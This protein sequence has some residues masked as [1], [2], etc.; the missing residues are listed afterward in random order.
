MKPG[1]V[2]DRSRKSS[3]LDMARMSIFFH[4]QLSLLTV[5]IK[6]LYHLLV[7]KKNDRINPSTLQVNIR[8]FAFKKNF[9]HCVGGFSLFSYNLLTVTVFSSYPLVIVIIKCSQTTEV[10]RPPLR[11]QVALV[12]P[13]KQT[14]KQTQQ[15]FS[16][17]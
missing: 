6:F 11:Q 7:F 4:N 16:S 5:V 2:S 13:L 15:T 3:S 10:S 8:L 9:S 12:L 1:D 14:N 17:F